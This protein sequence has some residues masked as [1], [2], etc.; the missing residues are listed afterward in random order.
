MVSRQVLV[1]VVVKDVDKG[2]HERHVF[3]AVMLFGKSNCKSQEPQVEGECDVHVLHGLI[4]RS[5][6]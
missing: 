2:C 3:R 4:D 1:G 6:H 5:V